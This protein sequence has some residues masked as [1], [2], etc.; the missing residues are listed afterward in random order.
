[1]HASFGFQPAIGI[2]ALH[3]NGCRFDSSLFAS[4]LF[5]QFHLATRL[6][7]PA[8]VHAQEHI[9]PIL[10]FGAPCSG[11][12][13]D[14]GIVAVGFAR[15]QRLNLQAT[16]FSG[17]LLERGDALFGH[18]FIAFGLA[19]LNEFAGVGQVGAHGFH[20]IDRVVELLT[21][22]HQTLGFLRI[23]PEARVFG[24][25]V[26]FIQAFEGSIPVKDASLAG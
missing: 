13:F 2:V 5:E 19:K 1:V 4:L 18:F 14:I 3:E 8:G 17:Q 7:S 22:T 26:Q 12:N 24:Q 20:T 9:C 16:G 6:L 15:K 11:M 21:L 23:I 10:A 25:R